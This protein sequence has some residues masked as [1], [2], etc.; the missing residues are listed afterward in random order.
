[1]SEAPEIGTLA[2]PGATLRY[3]VR[4]AGPSLLLIGG[5]NSGAAVFERL[6]AVLAA[7][8]RVVSY[9]PRGISRSPLDGRPVD[10]SIEVHADDAYRLLCRVTPPGEAASVFGGCSGGSVALQLAIRQP[11][12]VGALVVHELP[13]FGLLPDAEAA[14]HLAFIDAVYDTFRREGIPAAMERLS[15]L[16]GGR[17][18]PV[19]PEARDNTAFFLA[20][21]LRP[22]TRFVPGLAALDAMAERTVVAGGRDS[23]TQLVHRPAVALAERFRQELVEFPGGHVGYAKWPDDFG[24]LLRE[25]LAALPGGGPGGAD[26]AGP[27]R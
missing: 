15:A 22:F 18:A 7:T 21:V 16:F 20:H 26:A 3:E 19:L 27:V 24:R 8:H 13:A 1:M 6:A 10:Q 23:R 9:D 4:G 5:G 2:V 11:E 25:V 12:M 14:E 17:P